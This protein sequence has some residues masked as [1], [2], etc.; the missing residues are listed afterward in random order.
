LLGQ[1][2]EL[3]AAFLEIKN[4]TCRVSLLEDVLIL[5]MFKI[6][7]PAPT[8]ARKA[9]GSNVLS[10]GFPIGATLS[11]DKRAHPVLQRFISLIET[12]AQREF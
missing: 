8:L 12:V 10:A 1:D 2:S 5:L 7:L 3:D 4:R 11:S 9:L 6:V